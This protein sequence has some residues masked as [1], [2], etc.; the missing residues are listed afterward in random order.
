VKP[1]GQVQPPLRRVD[2]DRK[3]GPI[4]RALSR[5]SVTKL[6]GWMSTN[7]A[8]KLDPWLLRLS[9]GRLSSAGPLPAALLETTGARSGEP[10]GAAVLYFNDGDD[11]IVI[12]SKRGAPEHPAWFHNLREHPD[13]RLGGRPFRAEIVEGEAERDRIWAIGDRVFPPYAQYRRWAAQTG[14][15]IPI[16]R[17]H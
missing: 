12:A 9:R 2:P 4:Y 11:I 16:V 5:F 6:G 15:E 10:R 13:V 1:V 14:R 8:W 7:F 3:R 17:L